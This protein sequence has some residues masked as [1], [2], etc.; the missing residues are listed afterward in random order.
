MHCYKQVWK[1]TGMSFHSNTDQMTKLYTGQMCHQ[2]V[3]PYNIILIPWDIISDSNLI[4]QP[5]CQS[6]EQ[7]LFWILLNKSILNV[8]AIMW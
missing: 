5:T 8:V 3:F 6:N 7:T 1:P 2:L 4:F